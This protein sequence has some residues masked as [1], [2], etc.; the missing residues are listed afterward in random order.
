MERRFYIDADIPKWYSF[1]FRTLQLIFF[2]WWCA[3]SAFYLTF[4]SCYFYAFEI[5][6]SLLAVDFIFG[7]NAT[8]ENRHKCTNHTS[9]SSL[10]TTHKDA[11]TIFVSVSHSEYICVCVSVNFFLS[12]SFHSL[13]VADVRH[14]LVVFQWSTRWRICNKVRK[15]TEPSKRYKIN[16]DDKV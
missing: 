5:L 15:K 7:I 10:H 12:A 16:E 14:S 6:G 11:S 13:L 4:F 1:L 2:L 9:S 3:S 8:N